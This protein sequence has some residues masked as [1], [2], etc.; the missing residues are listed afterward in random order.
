MVPRVIGAGSF[1]FSR[2]HLVCLGASPQSHVHTHR[3][4]RHPCS[5]R[6]LSTLSDAQ[7]SHVIRHPKDLVSS[8]HCWRNQGPLLPDRH[9]SFLAHSRHSPGAPWLTSL[10]SFITVNGTRHAVCAYSCQ[11]QGPA[12]R[13]GCQ[14]TRG[15]RSA[16]ARLLYGTQWCPSNSCPPINEV[17]LGPC[18]DGHPGGEESGV[19]VGCRDRRWQRQEGCAPSPGPPRMPVT[20]EATQRQE[21]LSLRAAGP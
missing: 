1:D 17:R 14:H 5:P 11:V 7:P 10:Q 15:P 19:G 3:V 18:H 6:P 13:S 16:G 4:A 9:A 20:L 2:F 12:S 8:C 21:G